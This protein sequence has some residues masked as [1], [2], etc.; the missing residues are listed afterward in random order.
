MALGPSKLLSMEEQEDI[1]GSPK[2]LG[3]PSPGQDKGAKLGEGLKNLITEAVLGGSSR[4]FDLVET[5]R[6]EAG[7]REHR[8]MRELQMATIKI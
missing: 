8:L 6:V 7:E 3:D 1:V 2:G 5:V 4:V